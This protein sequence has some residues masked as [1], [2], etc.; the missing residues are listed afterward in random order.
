MHFRLKK[1]GLDDEAINN[2]NNKYFEF[3]KKPGYVLI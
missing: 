2:L 1:K 3:N